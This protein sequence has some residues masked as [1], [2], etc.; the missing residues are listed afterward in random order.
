ME[1]ILAFS[2]GLVKEIYLSIS[3]GKLKPNHF[4]FVFEFMFSV[5]Y[6][7]QVPSES[8]LGL[9]K[10]KQISNRRVFFN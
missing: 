9:Y 1:F 4:Y 2:L 7:F 10:M 5:Q 6:N 8:P 3:S